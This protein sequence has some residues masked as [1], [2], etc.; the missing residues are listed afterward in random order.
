MSYQLRGQLTAKIINFRQQ[1]RNYSNPNL[2]YINLH[3]FN[4]WHMEFLLT[5]MDKRLA[6]DLLKNLLKLQNNFK[7]VRQRMHVIVKK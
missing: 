3:T 5:E 2:K 6:Y 1:H 4:T 7:V